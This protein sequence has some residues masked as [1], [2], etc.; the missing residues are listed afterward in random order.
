M[1]EWTQES[2]D[3]TGRPG[4]LQLCGPTSEDVIVWT[5][6]RVMT[7]V[8]LSSTGAD[9]LASVCG[10][11]SLE[12]TTA[13]GGDGSQVACRVTTASTGDGGA[14]PNSGGGSSPPPAVS[15][16]SSTS[17]L[18]LII[19]AAVVG[20]VVGAVCLAVLFFV[21]GRSRRRRRQA[22]AAAEEEHQVEDRKASVPNPSGPPGGPLGSRP[23]TGDGGN[24]LMPRPSGGSCPGAV[25][26]AAANRVPLHAIARHS[27]TS[28]GERQRE[29]AGTLS[30]VLPSDPRRES[31]D[32]R[33]PTLR[34]S[35]LTPGREAQL[36]RAVASALPS[37]PKDVTGA[38]GPDRPML[39]SPVGAATGTG[40][41]G[42]A[43]SPVRIRPTRKPSAS[44]DSQSGQTSWATAVSRERLSVSPK[45]Q[46]SSIS[47][48]ADSSPAS[49][50]Y[51]FFNPT[52]DTEAGVAEPIGAAGSAGGTGA[53]GAAA[54]GGGGGPSPGA[55]NADSAIRASSTGVASR[56][57][58]TQPAR[59]GPSMSQMSLEGS[60]R[61]ASMRSGLSAVSLRNV[62][63]GMV[64]RG[65]SQ[66]KSGPP[67]AVTSGADRPSAVPA[68]TGLGDGGRDAPTSLPSPAMVLPVPPRLGSP[69]RHASH[70]GPHGAAQLPSPL[71]PK[72]AAPSSQPSH[73]KPHAALTLVVPG[74]AAGSRPGSSRVKFADS[75]SPAPASPVGSWSGSALAGA[76]AGASAGVTV[77]EGSRAVGSELPPRRP[78]LRKF[79][80]MS[81]SAQRASLDSAP[82][83]GRPGAAT[84]AGLVAAGAAASDVEDFRPVP[85]HK[86]ATVLSGSP[87]IRRWRAAP[88]E[89]GSDGEQSVPQPSNGQTAVGARPSRVQRKAASAWA[90]FKSINTP[91][92]RTGPDL[93]DDLNMSLPGSSA[94]SMTAAAGPAGGRSASPL[95][96]GWAF[97]PAAK[98][99]GA[100]SSGP[101]EAGS[102]ADTGAGSPRA[103]PSL[104]GSSTP[105]PKRQGSVGARTG[106]WTEG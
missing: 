91:G 82:G 32:L 73:L 74:P 86:S 89:P 90:S 7:E 96:G 45:A 11:Q 65:D 106:P 72:S 77:V 33:W 52:F 76:G 98:A 94:P 48:N 68:V 64:G 58:T 35:A 12:P 44:P 22:A 67:P 99:P 63:L 85:R 97:S 4:G 92:V 83:P 36:K 23:G 21:A 31:V 20:A 69:L 18:P 95:P 34:R 101:D 6:V 3:G 9:N 13:L 39:L 105:R 84:S 51:S 41:P 42:A 100:P 19:A 54:V 66:T 46:V 60:P 29:P 71:G 47:G 103:G 43:P 81:P 55:A 40:A 30:I 53:A 10:A 16:A 25:E 24:Q 88:T 2:V 37:A 27:V 62:M 26:I 15:S 17:Y 102:R 49:R 87:S 57:V 1:D 28:Q 79:V 70:P 104:A 14:K 56:S 75:R 80:T 8:P 78:R 61:A 50:R 93:E 59:S 5:N 38:E